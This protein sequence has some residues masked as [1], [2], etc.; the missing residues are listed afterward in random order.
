MVRLSI[1]IGQKTGIITGAQQSLVATSDATRRKTMTVNTLYPAIR[2][3]L[4]DGHQVVRQGLRLLMK[5]E[6]LAV[7]GETGQGTAAAELCERTDPDV[8]LVDP[9][10]PDLAGVELLHEIRQRAPRARVVVL[11]TELDPRTVRGFL[12]AGACG[13]LLKRIDSKGLVAA[14]RNAVEGRYSIEPLAATVLARPATAPDDSR[15]TPRERQ[16]LSLVA[17]GL[18][19]KVIARELAISAG[20]VRVYLS[21]ILVKLG[22]ANRTEAAMIGLQRGLVAHGQVAGGPS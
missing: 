5:A 22:A 4:V 3:V 15:L 20:T 21:E 11:T 18:T 10:M 8:V 14:I 6:G 16:V 7:V 2:V 13:Y 1:W 9:V 17:R 12:A 19:N